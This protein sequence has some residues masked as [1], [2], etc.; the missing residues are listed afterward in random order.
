MNAPVS[1]KLYWSDAYR[2]RFTARVLERSDGPRPTAILNRTLFY[3]EGGGQPHD[4]GRLGEARV[5]DVQ[6]VGDAIIHHL[7]RP[8]PDSDEI[9]GTIDWRQRW[10]YMQQH[11][12]QHLLSAAF[13]DVLDRP[14]IGFHLT[15]DSATIDI[16]GPLPSP[17]EITQTL[18]F[19]QAV[20]AA[21]R[22]ILS[23]Q[24]NPADIGSIPLRKPPTVDGPVR[25]VEIE[26][27]D[28][29]ACGGTH[30]RST[31]AI[32]LIVIPRLERRG[33]DTRVHFLCGERAMADYKDRLAVTTGLMA[34]LTT[35]LDDI[36]LAV[37]RL[38][39]QLSESQ[40]AQREA[41]NRLADAES[42]RLIATASGQNGLRLVQHQLPEGDADFMRRLMSALTQK[43]DVVAMLSVATPALRW[44][45]GRSGDVELNLQSIIPAV[46]AIPGLQGG[47]N[48][49]LL[50]GGASDETA[51]TA[52][53]DLLR[54]Q[55]SI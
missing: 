50:Q 25:V 31:A 42:E 48:A 41:T 1:R 54:S 15:S 20:I 21:D 47:G 34:T 49:E 7:D 38:Q 5:V 35:G 43:P 14:T 55:L 4:T 6:S 44:V 9:D 51:L 33:N 10:D 19:A 36:A 13:V 27:T 37:A 2:T 26:E 11:S 8:L 39:S 24:V 23:Y 30:V 28:W 29:S 3:P 45:I 18:A 22:R 53:A 17:D 46:R 40:K 52:L 32:A 16:P 12:G